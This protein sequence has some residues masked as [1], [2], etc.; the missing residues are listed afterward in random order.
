MDLIVMFYRKPVQN[1]I[2][3]IAGIFTMY[4]VNAELMNTSFI[5]YTSHCFNFGR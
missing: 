1:F 4:K 2:A 5:G 3:E